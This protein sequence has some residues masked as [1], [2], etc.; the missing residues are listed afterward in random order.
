[1]SKIFTVEFICQFQVHYYPFDTQSCTAII[2]LKEKTEKFVKLKKQLKYSGTEDLGSYLVKSIALLPSDE[3]MIKIEIKLGRRLFNNM[4]TII[5]PTLI[6]VVVSLYIMQE[7]K[8]FTKKQFHRFHF[9]PIFLVW[10][11]SNLPL[12][13]I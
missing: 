11:N 3:N 1:M 2:A 5:L 13:S 6:L 7:Y 4:M 10:N 12:Q 8:F 9:P